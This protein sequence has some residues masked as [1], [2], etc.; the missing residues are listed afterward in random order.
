MQ[1]DSYRQTEFFFRR[2]LFDPD[3]K[4]VLGKTG[5][6]TGEEVLHLLCEQ[7]RTP[8]Y[9]AE[10]IWE[11]FAY[12]KP[13]QAVLNRLAMNFRNSGL[14]IRQLL[15]DVMEAPEFYSPKAE[16]AVYKNP[17]DF[18]V[19]TLRQLGVGEVVLSQVKNA[20][21][22]NPQGARRYFGAAVALQQTLDGMG[23]ELLFPP[24]VAGWDGGAAWISSAT[25]VERIRWADL[26]FGVAGEQQRTQ[27]VRGRAQVRYQAFPLLRTDPTPEG[28]V[29]KLVSVFDAK[30]PES[31][32]RSLVE[33]ARKASEGRLTPQN[34]NVTAAA[35]TRLIFGSPEFQMM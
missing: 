15:R 28:V 27:G 30:L 31:R 35:V 23:M 17:V 29:R 20:D 9:L 26:I 1:Q 18:A 34:A 8:I 32:T 33:A 7:A 13:E 19:S 25:M 11:W 22:N 3:D 2:N 24:D 5:P 10:K 6:Y 21:P 12:P 14:D 4:T 16:R